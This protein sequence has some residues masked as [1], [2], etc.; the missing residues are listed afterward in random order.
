[1]KRQAIQWVVD[2]V[3]AVD[4]EEEEEEDGG[5]I[6]SAVPTRARW[7]LERDVDFDRDENWDFGGLVQ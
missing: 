1:M 3:D 6:K 2:V 7:C 4:D 5:G